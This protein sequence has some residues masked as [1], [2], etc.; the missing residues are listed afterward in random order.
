ML[1]VNLKLQ[2][3][4][5]RLD[6]NFSAPVPGVTALFGR[7]GCGKTTV[8]NLLAGLLRRG[9][10]QLSLDDEVWF[11][12][13]R[14]IDV[15]AERRGI[16]YVFQDARLFPHYSVRGNL[17]YGAPRG[18][19]GVFDEVVGLLG[20]EALLPRRPGALSGGE[21]QRVALGRALLARPK[22]LLLD[23]PLASLDASRREEVLPYLARLRDHYSIPM[24]FV[25]HQ[26][27]EV[28]RLATHLVVM[29]EGRVVAAG[30]VN[31]VSLSPAL[32]DI[33]G[34]DATGA[35]IEGRVSGIDASSDLA[36]IAIGADTLRVASRSLALHQRVR[37]QLLARDMILATEEPRGISV[38]NHLRGR[39]SSIV[40]EAGG[41]LVEVD[42]GGVTVLARITSAAT[43]ELSLHNGLDVWVL[44]KAV[45]VNP[46]AMGAA[47]PS[48]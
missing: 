34:A 46:H 2:R 5:F 13:A 14:G 7:S 28:L 29:D 12:S 10:G 36:S 22:L 6:A 37:V 24:V 25:S 9:E 3:G 42:V 26:F 11:D 38:R 33:V 48:G 30:D 40:A 35:V 16:G 32:R 47:Q 15:P 39:V 27:D 23:E 8:V 44:V 45:S 41:D 31:A 1:Q 19:S 21:R 17:L 20:L 18:K 4:A 43:R